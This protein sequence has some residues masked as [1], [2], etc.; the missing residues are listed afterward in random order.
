MSSQYGREGG[1]GLADVGG[2]G[3]DRGR[4]GCEAREQRADRHQRGEWRGE[5]RGERVGAAELVELCREGRAERG[6]GLTE[7]VQE[8]GDARAVAGEAG[9]RDGRDHG[10]VERAERNLV[11]LRHR[12]RHARADDLVAKPEACERDAACP[13]ST[14]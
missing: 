2:V 4:G 5:Q 1:G 8:R 14:G 13:I 6:R 11:A 10:G 7:A 9:A 12:A 3:V